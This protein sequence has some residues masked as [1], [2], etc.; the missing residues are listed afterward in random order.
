MNNPQ[1]RKLLLVLKTALMNNTENLSNEINTMKQQLKH[2]NYYTPHLRAKDENRLQRLLDR[3]I[4]IKKS[5]NSIANEAYGIYMDTAQY[6]DR[7]KLTFDK[8]IN[9]LNNH[10]SEFTSEQA[11]SIL[12]IIKKE[13]DKRRMTKENYI[14]HFVYE[15]ESYSFYHKY[16]MRCLEFKQFIANNGLEIPDKIVTY[17][18]KDYST[19]INKNQ[20]YGKYYSDVK[21]YIECVE[22]TDSNAVIL[23][24]EFI[25]AHNNFVSCEQFIYESELNEILA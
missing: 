16:K 3:D 22:V 1:K 6:D 9:R 20:Y 2:R 19:F 11:K 13:L 24:N 18:A 12:A 21:H 4:E 8:I 23:L 15:I 25:N 7:I 5:F 14:K 17:K 10:K